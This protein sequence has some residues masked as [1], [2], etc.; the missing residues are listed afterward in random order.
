MCKCLHAAR[1]KCHHQHLGLTP[2]SS[3]ADV[4]ILTRGS[5]SASPPCSSGREYCSLILAA[6]PVPLQPSQTPRHMS[7]WEAWLTGGE[8]QGQMCWGGHRGSQCWWGVSE[9]CNPQGGVPQGALGLPTPC[10][11][12]W[13]GRPRTIMFSPWCGSCLALGIWGRCHTS[14]K[15]GVQDQ[16]DSCKDGPRGSP[17][18]KHIPGESPVPAHSVVFACEISMKGP[19]LAIY[20]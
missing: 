3:D 4:T 13:P 15:Q 5:S 1:G 20:I 12:G 6:S 14:Q 7:C 17:R 8:S 18:L 2:S 19:N 11:L 16:S 9:P 10:C